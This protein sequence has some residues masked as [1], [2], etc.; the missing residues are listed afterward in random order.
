M[1]KMKKL[2][3]L[4][5][6]LV[7][8]FSMAMTVTAAKGTNTNDGKITINNA[9]KG[10]TYTIYEILQ[11]ESYDTDKNAYSYKATDAWKNFIE[12]ADIKDVYVI[13]DANGYVTW[14]TGASASDFAAL[15]KE[16]A[17]KLD[18]NQGQKEAT[19]GTVEFT[20][21]NLGYY[22]VDSTLGTV[23]SLDTTNPEVTIEEKNGEPTVDKNVKENSNDTWGKKND[24][25][26]GDTVYFETTINV[27]DG[28]PKNYVLHD[29]M[30]EGLTFNSESVEVKV[31]GTKITGGYTLK[32]E[33]I[34]DE[35]TFEIT[36]ADGTLK[37]NDVVTVTYSAVLNEKA[38]IY[39]NAN[40]N[41]T[42]LDYGDNG[43]TEWV[44]TKTY[45]YKF[46]LVKTDTNNKVLTGAEFKLYDAETGG[47]E[48]AL[49]KESDGGYRVATSAE[50]S[51]SGF[52]A[53]VIEAGKVTI[54]GL[55]AG[56]YWLEETKAPEGYNKLSGRVEVKIEDKNLDATVD[57]GTWTA[58]G[59]KVENKTGTELPSTGGMGTTIF[60]VLGSILVIGA[61]VLLITRKRMSK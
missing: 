24:A 38:V 50:K 49:V 54:K 1:R 5:L 11:L 14:K 20:G 48:I 35:C 36:F 26:V 33:G 58:G 42:K 30:S 27:V 7:M 18:S 51:A 22:L 28:Q 17:K 12:S 37:P 10:Q 6:A 31:N 4:M 2:A 40:T 44:Q 55:D 56:T 15:A 47:N 43:T 45:T 52:E 53:A 32:T 61:A 57:A 29:K 25:S 34:T 13:V 59:V 46:D 8:V 21:L 19:S 3:S 23:C 60:Y 39:D 9:V 16:Y 41:D